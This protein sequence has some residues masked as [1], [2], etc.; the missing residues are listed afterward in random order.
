MSSL[1]WRYGGGYNSV[2]PIT[3]LLE[4]ALD[5]GD[6]SLEEILDEPDLLQQLSSSNLVLIEYLRTPATMK[7]LVQL[8]LEGGEQA[9]DRDEDDEG[10]EK[11]DQ[12]QEE[13]Q[14]KEQKEDG[15]SAL[16]DTG[17]PAGAATA[18]AAA[19]LASAK[20]DTSDDVVAPADADATPAS[21]TELSDGPSSDGEDKPETPSEA[22]A[23]RAQV[24]AE[25][26]SADVWLLTDAF[27]D[28]PDYLDLLWL[29]LDTTP[30]NMVQSTFFMKIN[31]HLLD[32]KVDEMVQFILQ[33]TNLV[34]RFMKHIDNPPLMDFLLKVISTDKPDLLTGI[35]DV[36]QEQ[37]L[38]LRLVGFLAPEVP[39]A[40]QLAAGDFLKAFV[41]ISANS[42]ADNSTIGPN[43]LTR[44]LVSEE[45]I[46]ELVRLMLHGGTLLANG[47]GIVIEIIR[48]NNSDYDFMQ[49]MNTTIHLHPPLP[50]DPV[51][52]GTMV[53]IFSK[54]MPEFVQMLTAPSTKRLETPF[55]LIE[56]LGFERFKVCELV[57]E[58]LHCSNMAL[59]NERDGRAKVTER[60]VERTRLK[61]AYRM[62]FRF[63]EMYPHYDLEP[64][65][66]LEEQQQSDSANQTADDSAT[67]EADDVLG[68]KDS[69]TGGL[70]GEVEG[71]QLGG[72][73][74]H[75]DDDEQPTA[76]LDSDFSA[77]MDDL[78]VEH[79]DDTHLLDFESG[80][81]QPDALEQQI[82]QDPVMGDR[83]KL[84]LADHNVLQ[85]ILGMFFAFPW[86]NF[87]H[88]V[89]FDIVQ[90]VLNGR[91]D[92]GYNKFL[93][94]DMFTQLRITHLI[95]EGQQKCE[96]YEE[97]TGLR[98][99][100]MGHLTLIAEEVVKFVQI[101]SKE[102]ILPLV[103]Q[104]AQEAEWENY[105]LQTLYDTRERYNAILGGGHR[106][107]IDDDES[108]D[109]SMDGED[110]DVEIDV[111]V[112]P[113]TNSLIFDP[114]V[115]NDLRG[116]G[117][118]A[119]DDGPL[120]A[121]AVKALADAL[122]ADADEEDSSA[123]LGA[124]SRYMQQQMSNDFP[125]G[126][127]SSDDEEEDEE[128][129]EDAADWS[130]GAA[131]ALLHGGADDDY[132]DPNDDGNS[133]ARPDHPLYGAMPAGGKEA[134]MAEEE[135]EEGS[136]S[137]EETVAGHLPPAVLTRMKL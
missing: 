98:L 36:L 41:T 72:A 115:D 107:L 93:A 102:N 33:Q 123:K 67:G 60:D 110:I 55:G 95:T 84:A 111:G 71:L 85:T 27:M 45:T 81:Q 99:G 47:V 8:T 82:R 17:V 18:A 16:T 49:V 114:E 51:Y 124:F 12:E 103:D 1:F 73:E 44:E 9:T 32:M 80:E 28:S 34:E 131:G 30:L 40:T 26:L 48:K 134:T 135:E 86:N 52:L 2:L 4:R 116:S 70:S 92:F 54:H 117:F 101:N 31:E 11:E 39:T 133:Y 121:D 15:D 61:Q 19:A 79:V 137:D 130:R 53:E 126:F 75:S 108:M 14:K 58:L 113:G 63:N 25:I 5:E 89:V 125:A 78:H 69:P 42:N 128:A 119:T 90:Q 10:L 106:G 100:Y 83:L 87:L 46:E 104:V 118:V 64:D 105:V 97:Q 3:T 35:I 77:T 6:V 136:D 74:H 7:Q 43:E 109:Q 127:G 94:I 21:E 129:V 22:K 122:V 88:N 76:P 65:T 38:I 59:I 66:T 112:E 96:D 91:M 29:C 57:A 62:A 20:E 68:A 56:P 24:A 13:E 132:E 50:R 37:Q 120:D 23:R